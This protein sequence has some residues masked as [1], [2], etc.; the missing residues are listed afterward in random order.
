MTKLAGYAR[1]PEAKWPYVLV[2][3]LVL[4]V[5]VAVLLAFVPEEGQKAPVKEAKK[6]IPV[7]QPATQETKVASPAESAGITVEKMV[8]TSEIDDRNHPM[9]SLKNISLKEHGTVYCYTRVSCLDIP[10]SIRHVWVNPAGGVAA[11]VK[12]NVSRRPV[13][14]YS[15]IS[16]Y[17]AKTGKWEFQVRTVDDKIVARR[18]FTAF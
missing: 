14:T 4:L 15:Y 9:D 11:D 16:L 12:L 13:D 7:I 2:I 17:G 1:R 5:C 8:F 18:S 3:T 10:Q 6:T